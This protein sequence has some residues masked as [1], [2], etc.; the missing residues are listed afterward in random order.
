MPTLFR[1]KEMLK[2]KLLIRKIKTLQKEITKREEAAL[3]KV[4]AAATAQAKRD[5]AAAM[6]VIN[7][8][9]TESKAASKALIEA[10]K[11]L[12]V[13]VQAAKTVVY[14]RLKAF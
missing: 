4:E 9:I 11:A 6:K 5:A 8:A 7:K 13:A 1:D 10:A 2:M 12:K 3:R 14:L